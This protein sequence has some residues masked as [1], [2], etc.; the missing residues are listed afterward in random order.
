VRRL[1]LPSS[2]D[3]FRPNTRLNKEIHVCFPF[4]RK[5]IFIPIALRTKESKVMDKLP[6]L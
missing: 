4:H 1:K 2:K 5:N 3:G 6:D